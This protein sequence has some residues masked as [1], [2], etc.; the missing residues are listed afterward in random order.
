MLFSAVASFSQEPVDQTLEQCINRDTKTSGGIICFS[1][2][3]GAGQR[4]IVPAHLRAAFTKA[5]KQLAGLTAEDGG[6][7]HQD[8]RKPAIKESEHAVQQVVLQL[9]CSI[10]PFGSSEDL[11]NIASGVRASATVCQDLLN[12]KNKG[13]EAM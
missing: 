13:K 3:P 4:W 2:H 10:N 5:C 1:L 9:Q 7:I 11:V 6:V 12:D 8:L